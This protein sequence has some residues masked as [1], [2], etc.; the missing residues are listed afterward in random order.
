[1][2]WFHHKPLPTDPVELALE[3]VQY[4]KRPGDLPERD[5]TINILFETIRENDLPGDVI[6]KVAKLGVIKISFWLAM[7][8]SAEAISALLEM[9]I[10]DGGL[11]GNMLR[12]KNL[13]PEHL[14]EIESLLMEEDTKTPINQLLIKRRRDSM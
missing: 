11:L 4:L 13:K 12:N 10:G 6:K 9:G 2:K 3:C 14:D 5:S 1:M 7:H 8:G